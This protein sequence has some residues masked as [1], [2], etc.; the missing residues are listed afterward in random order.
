MLLVAGTKARRR[1]GKEE[2]KQEDLPWARRRGDCKGP[3]RRAAGGRRSKGGEG[4]GGRASREGGREVPTPTRLHRPQRARALP[5]CAAGAGENEEVVARLGDQRGSAGA[6]LAGPD[7][8][9]GRAGSLRLS[10]RI[11]VEKL[12]CCAGR[13]RRLVPRQCLQLPAHELV[14]EQQQQNCGAALTVQHQG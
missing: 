14:E 11:G 13:C 10:G 6:G 4:E 9:C 8:H 3:R 5:A 7:A 2:E 1:E 12:R